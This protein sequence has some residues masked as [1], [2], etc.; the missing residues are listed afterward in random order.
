MISTKQEIRTII[1]RVNMVLAEDDKPPL[2]MRFAGPVNF[3]TSKLYQNM[4]H[5]TMIEKTMNFK[6]RAEFNRYKKA[7]CN[8][9]TLFDEYPQ[10]STRPLI[11]NGRWRRGERVQFLNTMSEP[12]WRAEVTW[13]WYVRGNNPK[14]NLNDKAT[15]GRNM[16]DFGQPFTVGMVI[17]NAVNIAHAYVK[18]ADL[19]QTLMMF[20]YDL[21]LNRSH[22]L[23]KYMDWITERKIG[24]IPWSSIGGMENAK[25][26][27]EKLTILM[28]E[29][30]EFDDE[31]RDHILL[32]GP[33]GVGK[34]LL[35]KG[36]LAR[37]YGKANILAYNDIAGMLGAMADDGPTDHTT[38]VLN[39]LNQLYEYTGRWTYLF[40]DEIDSIAQTHSNAKALLREMDN[41]G[42]R[43]FSIIGTTN[44]PDVMDFALFRPGR[45]YPIIHVDLP[46]NRDREDIWS[47]ANSRF[48]LGMT[49]A[50]TQKLTADSKSFSGADIIY[51]A[52]MAHRERKFA[53]I[54]KDSKFE[55]HQYI[56]KYISKHKQEISSK[57]E[58]WQT[59]VKQF[60]NQSEAT[61]MYV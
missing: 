15:N 60:L 18:E 27:M 46:D 34:T 31:E 59:R 14:T 12:G 9:M 45:F 43:K 32:V 39:F 44:R 55:S 48:E 30:T 50:D 57:N 4:N 33:P 10:V 52:R 21:D 51:I 61:V 7:V 24:K 5:V 29:N 1:K 53:K 49:E 47:I 22:I 36:M 38:Y 25:N 3:Q 8:S 37:L 2:H 6:S 42:K 13:S 41:V 19:F 40:I 35:I 58:A 16:F 28:D 23:A 56:L 17:C 20:G 11:K 26:T 54:H